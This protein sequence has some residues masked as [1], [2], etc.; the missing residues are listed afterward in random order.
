[1]FSMRIFYSA[2]HFIWCVTFFLTTMLWQSS[3]CAMNSTLLLS[4]D[5]ILAMT[6]SQQKEYQQKLT[7]NLNI[8]YAIKSTQ[9]ENAHKNRL[10]GEFL[11]LLQQ[12]QQTIVQQQNYA[13]LQYV[14]QRNYTPLQSNR[15]QQEQ[16]RLNQQAAIISRL[17]QAH[18]VQQANLLQHQQSA[19]L[20]ALLAQQGPP[21]PLR[22][23]TYIPAPAPAVATQQPIATPTLPEKED[24]A[25]I[26]G[27]KIKPQQPSFMQ[28]Q[29][30]SA[31]ARKKRK[32]DSSDNDG[33][34]SKETKAPSYP[35]EPLDNFF[36]HNGPDTAPPP[37]IFENQTYTNRLD[38]ESHQAADNLLGI[39]APLEIYGFRHDNREQDLL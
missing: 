29:R 32:S 34:S 6:E 25:Q 31:Q 30:T 27:A 8:L 23:I 12:P 11:M 7:T 4:D 24:D 19:L 10:I 26:T 33:S 38:D 35:I 5:Q 28:T 18:M 22:Q 14:Y 20:S 39:D 9:E 3:I 15:F 21:K 2:V 17:Y 16:D 13:A 37:F 1:M 36:A